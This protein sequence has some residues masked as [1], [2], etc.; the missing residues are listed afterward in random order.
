MLVPRGICVEEYMMFVMEMHGTLSVV[1]GEVKGSSN[2]S[3]G[4]TSSRVRALDSSHAP[5]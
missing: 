5:S 1:G 4:V 2:A 3:V